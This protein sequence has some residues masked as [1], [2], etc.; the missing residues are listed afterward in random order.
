MSAPV[1]LWT[2]LARAKIAFPGEWQF[3]QDILLF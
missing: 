2:R 3:I 1:G